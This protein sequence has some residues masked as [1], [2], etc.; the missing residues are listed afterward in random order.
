MLV[1][2]LEFYNEEEIRFMIVPKHTINDTDKSILID[3]SDK[4]NDLL[5]SV[6]LSPDC[7]PSE[8]EC[9]CNKYNIH[10]NVSVSKLLKKNKNRKC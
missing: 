10:C 1:K 8:L 5:D 2:R 6:V 9:I 4:W 3:L 7:T